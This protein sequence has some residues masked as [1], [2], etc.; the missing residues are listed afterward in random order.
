MGAVA[1]DFAYNERA[2]AI[3]RTESEVMKNATSVADQRVAA[4]LS[5]PIQASLTALA[6]NRAMVNELKS[7]L[8]REQSRQRL[9]ATL[10][11]HPNSAERVRH[12]DQLSHREILDMEMDG[13]ALVHAGVTKSPRVIAALAAY[14]KADADVRHKVASQYPSITLTPGYFFD[15]GNG[16]FSLIGDFLLPLAM[17]H[18]PII[19]AAEANRR[20]RYKE[21]VAVQAD[22]VTRVHAAFENF[23]ASQDTYR[24]ALQLE[25][26]M[27]GKFESMI[28]QREQ[29]VV[30][31]LTFLLAKR[32]N[33]ALRME[34]LRLER[35]LRQAFLALQ[36]A[37]STS[38]SSTE[39]DQYLDRFREAAI[40][41]ATEGSP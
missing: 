24:M 3:A 25:R 20:V 41:T 10:R 23:R 32:E 16:V 34:T 37:S 33:I 35:T 11:F 12:I 38:L 17:R 8:D 39:F 30:D 40:F 36:R 7:K 15:Q 5:D 27:A 4:G 19:A 1:I 29:G 2:Y 28:Q 26:E 14:Q 31:E 22:V 9:L 6:A 13:E 21:F 18:E